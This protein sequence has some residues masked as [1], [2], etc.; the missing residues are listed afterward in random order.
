MFANGMNSVERLTVTNAA[1]SLTDIKLSMT[2][3][4]CNCKATEAS[5]M[6]DGFL[7]G[8]FITPSGEDPTNQVVEAAKRAALQKGVA[9]KETQDNYVGK[10]SNPEPNTSII[11]SAIRRIT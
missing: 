3:R 10:Q 2:A 9:W 1:K 11:S 8:D 4:T 5:V 7:E 6:L